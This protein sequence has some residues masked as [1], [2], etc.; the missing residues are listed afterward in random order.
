MSSPPAGTTARRDG[1]RGRARPTRR[2]LAA[3]AIATIAAL[4]AGGMPA[5]AAPASLTTT[6]TL[7]PKTPEPTPDSTDSTSES[8]E[9]GLTLAPVGNGVVEPGDH[10]SASITIA[11]GT[12]LDLAPGTLALELGD[13]AITDSSRLEAWLAGEVGSIRTRS[14][15]VSSTSSVESDTTVTRSLS[16][17]DDDPAL[18]ERAPGVYPLLARYQRAG[19]E[20]VSTSAMIVPRTGSTVSPVAVVVPITAGPLTTGL[21]DAAQLEELTAPGGSLSEQLQAV[22]GSDAI[23]AVDPAIPAAIRVLGDTAPDDAVRWLE[24]LENL[25]NTRFALQFGDADAAAELAAGLKR[26][27]GPTTLQ[28]A[29][30]LEDFPTQT[31]T[32]TPTAT[33][34]A[35]GTELPDLEALLGIGGGRSDLFW[36]APGQAGTDVVEA[37]ADTGPEATT[38]IPSETAEGMRAAQSGYGVVG[39]SKAPVLV[40]DSAISA[41]LREA[42]TTEATVLRGRPLTA[43]TALLALATTAAG[44]APVFVTVDR[45][46]DRSR[47]A[48]TAAISAATALPTTRAGSLRDLV[49]AEPTAVTIPDAEP[50]AKR[51]RQASALFADEADLTEFASILADPTLLTGRERAEVLQLLGVGWTQTTEWTTAFSGHREATRATLDAVSILPPSA[52]NLATSDASLRFWVRNE[53]PYPVSVRLVATPDDLRLDVQ[54]ET[55]IDDATAASN[56]RVAVPVRARISNGEVAIRLQ[57]LSPTGV[58]V[59]RAQSAAI[60]VRADWEGIGVGV[61]LALIGG[62]IALGLVRT[63]LRRRAARRRDAAGDSAAGDS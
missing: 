61:V 34:A 6:N 31:P 56:T 4:G 23:L 7:T 59:G 26:P 52:V 48:L 37:L 38:L 8:T 63:V 2:L 39:E 49:D 13:T 12:P 44:D 9:V 16:I 51:G 3:A 50:D 5:S 33:P 54:R 11:N 29:M 21:L 57:L 14:V 60:N 42:S 43:A 24:V 1:G 25:P 15:S 45:A 58:P 17:A 40:Y 18:A 62:F 30:S 28:Y 10:L 27:A 36:P 20:L 46:A 35:D 47:T 41:A 32:A 19:I 22:A 55:P 53:L